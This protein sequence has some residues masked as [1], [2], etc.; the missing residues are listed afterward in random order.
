MLLA[1]YSKS[2]KY[3]ISAMVYL[4]SNFG[5]NRIKVKHI[6]KE[7]NIPLQYL[8]KLMNDLR[9][10][11]LVKAMRG[12][13]G[14]MALYE[15]PS[16][17]TLIEIITAVNEPPIN[18]RDCLLGLGCC[19]EDQDCPFHETWAKIRDEIHE[20]IEKRTLEDFIKLT[21][22]MNEKGNE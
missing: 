5:S 19:G 9:Q 2:V 1:V 11:H 12:P 20:D 3:A 17:I 6:A 10:A 16:K 8:A 15:K 21:Y 18:D 13:T 22:K 7:C 4:A 14:G